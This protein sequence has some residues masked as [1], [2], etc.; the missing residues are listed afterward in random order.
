[1]NLNH[2]WIK[3]TLAIIGMS[4]LI[5]GICRVAIASS[6]TQALVDGIFT[7]DPSQGIP[8]SDEKVYTLFQQDIINEDLEGRTFVIKFDFG[9]LSHVD[10]TIVLMLKVDT[11]TE[12]EYHFS[13]DDLTENENT[14]FSL[15]KIECGLYQV[16]LWIFYHKP[17]EEYNQQFDYNIKIIEPKPIGI[18]SLSIGIAILFYTA[19]SL[20]EIISANKRCS[21]CHNLVSDK[22][23][24]LDRCP[25][26]GVIW[27]YEKT[28][29]E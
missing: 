16:E 23:H 19:T 29:V 26:C 5:G 11:V 20:I 8:V 28:I 13:L 12:L 4:M 2:K 15:K 21:N 6:H 10:A 25:H 22:Y 14:E 24:A 3:L 9:N 27:S 18:A 1:M 7:M 17:A